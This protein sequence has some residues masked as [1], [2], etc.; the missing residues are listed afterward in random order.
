MTSPQGDIILASASHSRRRL[1]EAAG[2][3]FRAVPAGVDE[4]AIKRN[5]ARLAIGFDALAAQLARQKALV[6]AGQ[7]PG[8]LVIGADQVLVFNDQAFDKPISI[9]SARQQ[10]LA[11]RGKTHCLETA[12]AC[13]RDQDILWSHI[14]TARLSMRDFSP[15]Y[16][17]SYLAT[18]G[19]SVTETVG[20][21]KIEGHGIQLF[22]DI[23]GDYFT[24]LGLP[25]LPLLEFLR[26]QGVIAR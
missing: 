6:V 10:L 18:E 23:D 17:T 12:V 25:L 19:I 22:S 3:T 14:A 16:L 5:H 15:E 4:T 11:L 21:Y 7:Y 26:A 13:A 1:L 8:Q 9:E 20:G 24:I 2:V